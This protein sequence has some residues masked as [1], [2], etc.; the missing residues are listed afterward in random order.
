MVSESL[1]CPFSIVPPVNMRWC[2]LI[3]N[4]LFCEV[5][6]ECQGCFM[7]LTLQARFKSRIMRELI[8][9]SKSH[10][11]VTSVFHRS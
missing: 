8:S 5:V 7:V 6:P 10:V 3:I 2:K 4:Y 9:K 11:F 1:D